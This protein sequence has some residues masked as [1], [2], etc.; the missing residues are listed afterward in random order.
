MKTF[1]STKN[2]QN[3]FKVLCLMVEFFVILSVHTNPL[4]IYFSDMLHTV[5]LNNFQPMEWVNLNKYSSCKTTAKV[6]D[7]GKEQK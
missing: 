6:E 5:I 2:V 4:H 3:A 7:K 1:S